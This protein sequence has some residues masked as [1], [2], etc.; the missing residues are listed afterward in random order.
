[1]D[2]Q[3]YTQK[4]EE[5]NTLLEYS[6]YYKL[7][8]WEQNYF[9]ELKDFVKKNENKIAE[10]KEHE[11]IIKNQNIEFEKE[12]QREKDYFKEN[13]EK[14]EKEKKKSLKLIKEKKDKEIK[15][16]NKKYNDLFSIL[17]T[18]ESKQQLIDFLNNLNSV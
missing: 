7:K 2:E 3:N 14:I 5:Y 9:N 4:I 8:R 1:M 11:E 12:I 6:K 10:M 18:I 17:E 16:N 15:K 13:I